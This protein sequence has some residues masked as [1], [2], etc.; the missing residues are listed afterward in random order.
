MGL[1]ATGSDI[2][3][4]KGSSP[5][6]DTLRRRLAAVEEEAARLMATLDARGQSRLGTVTPEPDAGLSTHSTGVHDEE[7]RR[8]TARFEASQAALRDSER[9][10]RMILES[11]TEYASFTMDLKGRVTAWNTG[12]EWILGWMEDE[13]L[14]RAPGSSSPPTVPN[15]GVPRRR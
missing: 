3:H 7:L 6:D 10:Q 1:N 2:K 13:I 12:V 5:D 4:D 14:G 8:S 9:R 15:A 11:A